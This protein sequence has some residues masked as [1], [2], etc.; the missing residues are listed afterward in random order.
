MNR[1]LV[2]AFA[3]AILVANSGHALA[4]STVA[5][6]DLYYDEG[7]WVSAHVDGVPPGREMADHRRYFVAPAAETP[8]Q[9]PEV[10]SS[11]AS[12]DRYYDEGSYVLKTLD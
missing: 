1:N 2:Q 10:F 12:I 11:V 6:S 3:A 5:G 4:E 8:G 9:E 7:V